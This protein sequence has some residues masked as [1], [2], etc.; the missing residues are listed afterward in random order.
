[1]IIL[2]EQLNEPELAGRIAA[3]YAGSVQV[4]TDLRPHSVIKDDSIGALLHTENEPTFVTINVTDFWRV[5][6]SDSRFAIVCLE[7]AIAQD[8][9]V[10]VWLRRFFKLP[11]FNTK[12]KRMGTVALLR[13][14]RIE[15]YRADRK[16]ETINWQ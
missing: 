8:Y 15:F 9:L 3:W 2:D 4:V 13:P 14:T 12:A 6:R 5:V 11:Q 1:M 16:I 7:L 10:P